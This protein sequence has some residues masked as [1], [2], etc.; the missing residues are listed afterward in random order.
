MQ[1]GTESIQT[2]QQS[3]SGQTNLHKIIIW[4][5]LG[6]FIAVVI[7]TI[8]ETYTYYFA[9]AGS[10]KTSI[11]ANK[12]DKHLPNIDLNYNSNSYDS[13]DSHDN[14]NSHNSNSGSGSSN[15]N[16]NS[17]TNKSIEGFD[18]L[19]AKDEV[20]QYSDII[21]YIEQVEEPQ[22]YNK[23]KV[24]GCYDN[25]DIINRARPGETCKSWYKKVTD[26]FFKPQN[27]T[28][29]PDNPSSANYNNYFNVDGQAQS[30][31]ELCPETTGQKDPIACLYDRA[32]GYDLMSRKIANI[33]DGIQ[34]NLDTKINNMSN[35]ANYHII[36]GNRIYNQS[37]IRD[38][39]GYERSLGLDVAIHGGTSGDQLDNLELYARKQRVNYLAGTKNS[40]TI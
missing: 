20:K 4:L 30:F 9:G 31:A 24:I 27:Q 3:T 40:A 2:Q 14:H 25:N 39:L 29:V 5:G 10:A 7:L 37:H 26:I 16:S 35:D 19:D 1:N 23:S 34:N 36:D 15:S 18:V 13:H 11:L 22:F 17:G 38:F 8:I 32:Q 28:Q 6:C 21:E 33:N 12:S